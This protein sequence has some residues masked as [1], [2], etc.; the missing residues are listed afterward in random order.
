MQEEPLSLKTR[1]AISVLDARHRWN[2]TSLAQIGSQNPGSVWESGNTVGLETSDLD[3]ALGRHLL[4]QL[5]VTV[6]SE[7]PAHTWPTVLFP[8]AV[9]E[10]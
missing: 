1:N 3:P 7:S 2:L 4:I 10:E 5:T 8:G 6:H 9:K